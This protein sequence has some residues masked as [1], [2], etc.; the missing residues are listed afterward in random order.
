MAQLLEE[1][2]AKRATLKTHESEWKVE[3]WRC[4]ESAKNVLEKFG[5]QRAVTRQ[6]I[7]LRDDITQLQNQITDLTEKIKVSGDPLNR[8]HAKLDDPQADK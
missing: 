1:L 5:N 2:V 8:L 3:L 4:V 6:I 7:K